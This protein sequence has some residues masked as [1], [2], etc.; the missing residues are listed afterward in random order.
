MKPLGFA[1][2]TQ[3]SVFVHCCRSR[4]YFM[5]STECT[6]VGLHVMC[7]ILMFD[8]Q[9]DR[10]DIGRG[11]VDGHDEANS[12]FSLLRKTPLKGVVM[13]PED[14]GMQLQNVICISYLDNREWPSKTCHKEP[15]AQWCSV[16]G[17]H[18]PS[19]SFKGNHLPHDKASKGTA[20]QRYGFRRNHSPVTGRR[21]ETPCDAASQPRKSESWLYICESKL[22]MNQL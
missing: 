21:R 20:Y 11:Q 18:L 19:V 8:R 6:S 2:E 10:Q 13:F 7:L 17:Q 14:W 1:V 4:K 9:T 15:L 3:E 22:L 16:R 5:L 12:C